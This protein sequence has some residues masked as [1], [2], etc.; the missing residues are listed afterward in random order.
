MAEFVVSAGTVTRKPS[1]FDQPVAAA[2]PT[3]G[4]TAL[5]VADALELSGGQTVVVVGATGGVGSYFVQLAAHRGARVVALCRSENADYA[6]GLGAIDVVDYSAGDVVDAVR[7]RYPDGLDAV[8]DMH[9]DSEQLTRLTER[10][11]SGGH[12]ASAVGAAHRG[13]RSAWRRGDERHRA[14]D[15][16]VARRSLGH[17]DWRGDSRTGDPLVLTGADVGEALAAVGTGHVRGKVV[18]AVQ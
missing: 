9:G 8:A 7:S 6:R 10:V 2:I 3:A 4:V 11:P 12:V 1:S 18:V 5:V 13:A 15:D 17:A 16:R 14:S